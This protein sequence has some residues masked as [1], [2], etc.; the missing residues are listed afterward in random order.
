[1]A[2]LQPETQRPGEAAARPRAERAGVIGLVLAESYPL[3]LEG[4]LHAFGSEPG[5][6]VVAACADGEEALRAVR[7]HHADV[8]VMDLDIAGDALHILK[9]LAGD[10]PPTRVVLLAGSLDEAVVLEA[11]RLGVKGIVLKSMARHLLVQCV[12]KVHA[13]GIWIEKVS[14]GRA[15]DQLLRHEAGYRDAA[16]LLT[17]R[18]LDVV[19]MA[20]AGWPN[21]EIADKLDICEGTVKA[22]LHHVYEKLGVKGRLELTLYA[23]DKGLFS[24]LFAGMPRKSRT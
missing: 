17:P 1:M 6:R 21:K 15:V 2:H 7:R 24:P 9:Q 14:M 16:A 3:L 22:H 12:R 19:R 8:L 20:T 11:V 10:R 18:E 5:V 4:M 23:R 13:G